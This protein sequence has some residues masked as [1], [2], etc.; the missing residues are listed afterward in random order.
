MGDDF[1]WWRWDPGGLI[2]DRCG[3]RSIWDP[4]IEGSVPGGLT[5]EAV[6]PRGLYGIRALGLS[7]ISPAGWPTYLDCLRASNLGAE[8]L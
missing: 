3:E 1:P 7:C 5:Q 8:G 2:D 6:A 4:N